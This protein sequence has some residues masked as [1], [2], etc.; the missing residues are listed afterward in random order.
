MEAWLR[1][2]RIYVAKDGK[3]PFKEWLRSIQ[4]H[5][6]L[7]RIQIRIDRLRLGNFGDC[8]S[9]G[10]GVHELR[11]DFGPGYR[12]YF[13]Q[14]GHDIVILLTGGAKDTQP[15]DIKRATEYWIDYRRRG[16]EKR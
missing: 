1:Q 8:K 10:F 3:Q 12:V 11:L 4:D 7:A 9:V 16:H 15:K 5:A 14:D 6:T 13:G 2:I